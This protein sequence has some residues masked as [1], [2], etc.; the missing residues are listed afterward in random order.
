M[1][2]STALIRSLPAGAPN[3]DGRGCRFFLCPFPDSPRVRRRR[4]G[5]PRDLR[6][7]LRHRRETPRDLR[8]A[9]PHRRETPRDLRHALPH[10]RETPRDLRQALLHRR[11]TSRGAGQPLR[12]AREAPAQSGVNSRSAR[13]T[14]HNPGTY[15]SLAPRQGAFARSFA[16]KR[17]VTPSRASGSVTSLSR[18]TRRA[19]ARLCDIPA[20]Q[21]G[22]PRS[23]FPIE[24]QVSAG[25]RGPGALARVSSEEAPMASN[26][27]TRAASSDPPRGRGHATCRSTM[28]SRCCWPT[29]PRPRCAGARPWS[30][31]I[32]R[33]RAPSSSPPA[34]R[35]AGPDGG[36]GRGLRARGAACH[37]RGQPAARH[38]G[39]RRSARARSRRRRAPRRGRERVL[40]GIPAPAGGADAAR[41]SRSSGDFQPLSS[42]LTGPA[43]T[44]KATQIVQAVRRTEREARRRGSAAR[45]PAS[46]LQRAPKGGAAR[47]RWPRSR[48]SRCRR[49]TSSSRRA[50]RAGGLH[51]GAG[52]ARGVAAVERRRRAAAGARAPVER[53]ALR[54]DGAAVTPPRAASVFATRP[55][56]LLVARREALEAVAG[57]RPGGGHRARGALPPAHGREPRADVARDGVRAPAGAR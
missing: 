27:P 31:A 48:R 37:R 45:R 46:A 29:R 30:S 17:T 8:H 56:I 1:A 3:L 5:A 24:Y 42:F 10:R 9:L 20:F 2:R 54:R 16:R 25:F 32:R 40:P 33:R 51:R 22:S 55:S 34:A 4:K 15:P 47:S 38:R 49:G 12:E 43:L 11:E 14:Q 52:R 28:P 13:D 26:R 39:H 53:R 57:K 18:T 7:T 41:R 35:A 6:H 50:R 19:D 23:Q 21:S 36:R 44:S